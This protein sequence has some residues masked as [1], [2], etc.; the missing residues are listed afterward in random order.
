MLFIPLLIGFL[1]LVSTLQTM[2]YSKNKHNKAQPTPP[3]PYNYGSENPY[4]QHSLPHG[5]PPPNAFQKQASSEDEILKHQKRQ[6]S[7]SVFYTFLF[8][9]GLIA[10]LIYN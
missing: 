5:Y 3:P 8:V 1:L 4:L 10:F 7:Q 9:L 2:L 6:A